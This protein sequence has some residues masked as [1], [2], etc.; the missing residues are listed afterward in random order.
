M[1]RI[2]ALAALVAAAFLP[3]AAAGSPPGRGHGSSPLKPGAVCAKA[4]QR[5]VW[6][7][8][9]SLVCTRKGR[10]AVWRL[11]P[12]TPNGGAGPGSSSSAPGSYG[13]PGSALGDGHAIAGPSCTGTGSEKLSHI[14]IAPGDFEFILPYGLMIDSHV[15]P[16]D[17]QYYSVDPSSPRDAYAVYAAGDAHIVNIQHRTEAPQGSGSGAGGGAKDEYRLVFSVSCTFFYYY[18][19]VTS[20]SPDIKAA[21]DEA[22]HGNDALLDLPVKAGQV[23]GRIGHQTLDF[24]VWDTTKTLA[25][26]VDPSDY[27][28][29]NEVW[30]V[31]VVDPLDYVTD[32]VR[33]QML[34]GYLRT[35][36]PLSGKLDW[37]V[38]G[39]L[40]GNWFLQGT[41]G[42]SGE[43]TNPHGY[44]VSFLSFAPDYLDPSHFVVSVGDYDGR[45]AQFE[46]LGNAPDPAT[47]GT[48]S[49]VVAYQL[50]TDG[51]VTPEGAAWNGTQLVRGLKLSDSTS[52]VGTV[53]VQLTGERTL[54]FEA[55]PGK[56]AGQVTGFDSAA[57][58]FTR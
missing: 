57:E 29:S 4:G 44:W 56:T 24:A 31:H 50:V 2:S 42:N 40:R 19:L 48:G 17:H 7:A 14:P 33:A 18:D 39:R 36:E 47:V 27:T 34:A 46:I 54:R 41:K 21:F 22:Q 3:V 37:D 38:D 55:F 11:V 32:A 35:A 8:G 12:G 1:H 6:P 20:L 53:L 49:G 51:Y 43:P 26:F 28:T 30:K 25:G 5:V 10:R 9:G 58:T 45:P 16:V 15:L 52:V 23:I 13:P